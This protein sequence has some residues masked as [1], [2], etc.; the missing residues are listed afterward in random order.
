MRRN[1]L[2][3]EETVEIGDDILALFNFGSV[4]VFAG[5]MI[6]H[7]DRVARHNLPERFPPD[8]ELEQQVSLAIKEELETLDAR[9]G[10]CSAACGSDLL[11]AERMLERGAE[12]HIVLPFDREDFYYT[13]V[14]LGLAEL[15]GWRQRCDAVLAQ[16]TEVHYA[17]T[18][19][20][21]GDD[22]LFAFVNTFTQGLAI[23]R[24]AQLGVQPCALAVCDPAAPKRVGGTAYFVDKWAAGGRTARMIDLAALRS[25]VVPRPRAA[26]EHPTPLQTTVTVGKLKRQVKAMLFADVWNF[27]R[28]REAQAP[29]FMLKFLTEVARVIRASKQA[30]ATPGVTASS[31][32][33]TAS[34]LVLIWPCACSTGLARCPG[35]SWACRPTPRSGSG[36]TPDQ[37]IR[38]WT[39]SL[40]AKTSSAA[41]ST[42][43]PASSQSPPLAAPSPASSSPRRSPRTRPRF[44]VRLH[45]RRAVGKRI[46]SLSFVPAGPQILREIATNRYQSQRG[47]TWR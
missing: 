16:A 4:V 46:R 42:G 31:S 45:W 40:D 18:E 20:F 24:A 14:D 7:P 32:S 2:L 1:L 5:H 13:S 21:L 27:S 19:N 41:T 35:P 28:L 3:L 25:R 30:P 39:R 15:S 23:T 22:V 43:R 33:S 17:T 8:P 11:F 10:Y 29:L 47:I 26:W 36:C 37:S 9:F 44:R 34:L 6:D 38:I 12:L